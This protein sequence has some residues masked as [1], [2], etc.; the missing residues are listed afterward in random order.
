MI[1]IPMPYT[2]PSPSSNDTW[3]GLP[4]PADGVEASVS[5][6]DD[7]PTVVGV[8]ADGAAVR[9]FALVPFPPPEEQAASTSPPVTPIVATANGRRRTRVGVEGLPPKRISRS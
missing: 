7:L 4:G 9:V 8:D 1:G 2:P 5:D 3:T 6:D